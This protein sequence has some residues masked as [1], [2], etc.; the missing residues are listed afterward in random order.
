MLFLGIKEGEGGALR[1]TDVGV[2]GCGVGG[3]KGSGGTVGIIDILF[4]LRASV[5]LTVRAARP[6]A[7]TLLGMM[8][9]RLS[10]DGVLLEV[11]ADL[12]GDR[13]NDDTT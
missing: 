11:P 13:A 12:A 7:C 2:S 10:E 8:E 1:G 3:V 4:S 5:G 6:V 9:S